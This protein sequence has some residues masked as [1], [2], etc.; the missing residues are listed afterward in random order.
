MAISP[1]EKRE[2]AGDVELDGQR[3]ETFWAAE[4]DPPFKHTIDNFFSSQKPLFSLSRRLWNP[5][6]D[7]Y[8]TGDSIIVKMEVAGV[9]E[10]QLDVRIVNHV[11]TIRGVRMDEQCLEAASVHLLE[12]HYGEFERMFKLPSNIDGEKIVASYTNGFIRVQVPK[13]EGESRP[14]N[15]EVKAGDE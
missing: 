3:D 1:I 10:K 11:L 9:D 8:E 7:V 6:T 13:A 14:I 15:V 12:V 4:S 2:Q 5:P